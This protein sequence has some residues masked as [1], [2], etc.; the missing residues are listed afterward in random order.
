MARKKEPRRIHPLA[1]VEALE[2]L[3]QSV[4]WFIA[5]VSARAR[6]LEQDAIS[7]DPEKVRAL[8]RD[9]QAD[10]DKLQAEAYP[11]E[12]DARLVERLET[13]VPSIVTVVSP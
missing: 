4:G 9:L 10:A 6:L 2:A 13:V 11:Q 12:G 3:N 8:A 1:M 5:T 7:E